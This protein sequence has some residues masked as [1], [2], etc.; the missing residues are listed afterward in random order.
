MVQTKPEASVACDAAVR[1]VAHRPQI[2][3][4]SLQH[5]RY[6]LPPSFVPIPLASCCYGAYAVSYAWLVTFGGHLAGNKEN[7]VII[8]IPLTAVVHLSDPRGLLECN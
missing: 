6:P 3:S 1:F 4:S 8:S 5:L 2:A 7:A